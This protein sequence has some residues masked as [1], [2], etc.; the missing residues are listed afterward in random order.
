MVGN[1]TISK[2]KK[3][4]KGYIAMIVVNKNY[5]GKGLAKKLVVNFIEDLKK[6]DCKEISLETECINL[7]ALALYKSFFK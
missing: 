4:L 3:Y 6:V 1:A 5:R 7:G 2:K